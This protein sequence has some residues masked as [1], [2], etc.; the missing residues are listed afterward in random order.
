MVAQRAGRRQEIL[1]AALALVD[2]GG[3][4]ALTMGRLAAASG[5]S[6]GSIYHHFGSRAGVLT[7]L[8]RDSFSRCVAALAVALDDRPAARVVP[9]LAERFLDWVAE[10]PTRARFLYT[11]SAAPDLSA[12]AD[13]VQRHK[14]DVF[15]PVAAWMTQRA[16]AGELRR[17]PVWALDPVVMG[18]AHECARRFLAAPDA[19]DLA[20]AR[21][22][23]AEATWA[24]VRP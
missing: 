22:V 8:Y 3:L 10:H 1:D 18:P 19:F 6:N 13:E 23:V 24:M 16:E 4:T 12:A 20:A 7:A 2:G 21:G 5:A 14:S 15:A 17:L 11:A 9:E